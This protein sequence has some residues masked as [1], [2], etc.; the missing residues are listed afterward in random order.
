MRNDIQIIETRFVNAREVA[1][2]LGVSES[3]GYRLI[4]EM[5]LEL[6]KQGKITIA[7]KISRRYFEEKVYL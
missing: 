3:T 4:R 6:K 1:T 2:V 7:G 5:N